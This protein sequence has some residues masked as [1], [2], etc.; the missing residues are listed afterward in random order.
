[1]ALEA[2]CDQVELLQGGI[3]SLSN[4]E[5][6]PV[7]KSLCE[8]RYPL[9]SPTIPETLFSPVQIAQTSAVSD[10]AALLKRPAVNTDFSKLTLFMC[11]V[12]EEER[13]GL[14]E[15]DVSCRA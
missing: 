2:E 14:E 15:Q 7:R 10:E 3:E 8:I 13:A 6:V 1:M 5:I 11:G 12:R 4:M 9:F